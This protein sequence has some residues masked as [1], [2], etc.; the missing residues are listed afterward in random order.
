MG[1]NL[2]ANRRSGQGITEYAILASL[3]IL[4]ILAVQI[5][6][7]RSVQGKLKSSSD[8]IGEQ[9][10]IRGHSYDLT[11]H[12]VGARTDVVA[13]TTASLGRED[14]SSTSTIASSFDSAALSRLETTF[15]GTYDYSGAEVTRRTYG[16]S[17]ADFG[18]YSGSYDVINDTAR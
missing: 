1:F 15:G 16:G 17:G 13:D 10:S 6:M 7:K 9:F 18:D 8:D 12:S 5:Y 14:Q 11:S 4:G 2:R 3:V